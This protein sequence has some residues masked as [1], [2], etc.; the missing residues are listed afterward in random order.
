[1]LKLV[2]FIM[3]IAN[4]SL[5]QFFSLLSFLLPIFLHLAMHLLII[6]GV[7]SIALQEWKHGPMSTASACSGR[8]AIARTTNKR[9]ARTFISQLTNNKYWGMSWWDCV[10]LYCSS[11]SLVCAICSNTPRLILKVGAAI[12]NTWSGDTLFPCAAPRGLFFKTQRT[13]KKAV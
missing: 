9:V 4:N 5:K 7:V 13:F 10:S 1:M 6:V 11:R 3:Y 8:R 2:Q 12:V